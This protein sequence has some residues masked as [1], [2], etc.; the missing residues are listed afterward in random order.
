MLE[1]PEQ[2]SALAREAQAVRGLLFLDGWML[3]IVTKVGRK[4]Q[5]KN[6]KKK[7]QVTLKVFTQARDSLGD[8][9]DHLF[10]QKCDFFL[11]QVTSQLCGQR[12]AP[13]S[14]QGGLCR[15]WSLWPR[16]ADA[17]GDEFNGG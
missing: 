5:N 11:S 15:V 13:R 6:K 4:L 1:E 17:V 8:V 10:N 3:H 2:R 14:G 12:A 9:Y 16:S 7:K